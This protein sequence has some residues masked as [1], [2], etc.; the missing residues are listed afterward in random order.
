MDN[1]RGHFENINRKR[2]GT[3]TAQ[4][5][6]D[7][8][9]AFN[10]LQEVVMDFSKEGEGYFTLVP[11]EHIDDVQLD[12]EDWVILLHPTLLHGTTNEGMN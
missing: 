6:I 7:K 9:S 11:I 10:P 12:N 3:M 4:Q 5:L 1:E 8:L 2:S